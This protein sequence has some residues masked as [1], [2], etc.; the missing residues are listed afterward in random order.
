MLKR[1]IFFVIG[2]L[3]ATVTL[4]AFAES[5]PVSTV[6]KVDQTRWFSTVREACDYGN[7]IGKPYSGVSQS[8]FNSMSADGRTCI[9]G[10]AGV[11]FDCYGLTPVQDFY[12]PQGVRNGS[13]CDIPEPCPSGTVRQPDGTCSAPCE[14]GQSANERVPVAWAVCDS[15]SYNCV[16]GGKSN[17]TWPSTYC[18]G[19]CIVQTSG[20][21]TGSCGADAGASV[22]SPKPI[23]CTLNGT[24][25]AQS[26]STKT[27]FSPSAPPAIPQK[28]PPCDAGEGV[29]T[30]SSGAVKCVPSSTP[31]NEPKQSNN[32]K[33][34]TFPDGSTRTTERT[35]T[36]DPG[37]GATSE[38]VKVTNTPNSSGGQGQAGVV[39]TTEGGT[40]SSSKSSGKEQESEDDANCDPK[41]DMCGNPGTDGIYTK[42]EKT[43]ASVFTQFQNTIKGSAL[44][45]ASTDFF[46]VSTPGGSCP[47]W[48][49]HVPML[50]IT[51]NA[52]DYFC[53][54]TILAALQGAGYVMLALATYIAFT[55][56]FL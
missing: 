49:V 28:K 24:T 38:G 12:C 18:D 15:D 50:D 40:E 4:T 31:G 44:G 37:T 25:T 10:K 26:C 8:D 22:D 55:W 39:G 7:T 32:K 48:S 14:A 33:V 56:A 1:L 43:M 3:F 11:C 51:L 23:R 36:T 34:E 19:K 9:Y 42:K 21:E 13:M 16:Y 29:L 53:N 27:D 6:Y 17:Y 41:K 35:T 5:V 47:A 46:T 30:S 45:S 54:G 52:A 20:V 2:V